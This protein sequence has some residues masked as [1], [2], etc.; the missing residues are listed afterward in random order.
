VRHA[1]VYIVS[2]DVPTDSL[3]VTGITGQVGVQS[4]QPTFTCNIYPNPLTDNTLHIWA[5]EERPMHIA[6]IDVFGRTLWNAEANSSE[7]TIPI[8]GLP[9][10]DYFLRLQLSDR[11]IMRKISV[12]R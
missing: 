8:M 6:I 5:S 4:E 1:I 11:V 9:N 3:S 12:L 7:I 2:T 10:G